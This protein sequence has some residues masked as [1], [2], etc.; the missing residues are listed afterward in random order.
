[1]NI[2]YFVHGFPPSLSAGAIN[3]YEIAKYLSNYGHKILVLCPGIL[4]RKGDSNRTI[5]EPNLNISVKFSSKILKF[6]LNL[7]LSHFENMIRYLL[8]IKNKFYAD[9]IIS[10]YNT[11]QYASV[12]GSFVSRILGIPHII[13]S[14]DTLLDKDFFKF[15]MKT[16]HSLIYPMIFRS[17][18][19]CKTFYALTSEQKRNLEMNQ[20]LN[21]LNFKTHPNGIDINQ[22]YPFKNQEDLKNKLGCENVLL[23]LGNIAESVG[24]TKLINVLPRIFKEHKETHLI[25]IGD[26]NYK[27]SLIRDIKK[28]PYNNQIHFLGTKPHNE[29]PFYI[30]NCDIGIGRLGNNRSFRYDLP[31]KFLEYMACKLPYITVPCSKDLLKKNDVGLLLN[32]EFS[33]D[34]LFKKLILLIEDKSL[35]KKLGANGYNKIINNFQW[36]KVMKTFNNDLIQVLNNSN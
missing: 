17:I 18:L 31:N 9:I 36:E 20:K 25:I 33:N 7:T 10:Q 11:Y 6:P 29:I 2:I 15:P 24:L 27:S 23:Y 5:I 19:N 12:V 8:K 26:G 13:R 3:A 30:N 16:M 35:R 4:S 21:N 28:S 34:E 1:M 22:F 32:W 14:H